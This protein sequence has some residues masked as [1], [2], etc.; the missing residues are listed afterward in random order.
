MKISPLFI[1]GNWTEG[2]VLDRHVVKSVP[3]G[4]DQWG[5]MR[6][7]TTRSE[8]GELLYGLKNQGKHQN[9]APIVEIATDFLLKDM[10]AQDAEFIIPVP[11]TDTTRPYQPVF[12]IARGIA[13]RMGLEYKEVL[14]KRDSIQAKN[15]TSDT[16]DHEFDL[17]GTLPENSNILL[18]DD[19]I[20]TGGTL[21]GCIDA[22]QRNLNINRCYV[23]ALTYTKGARI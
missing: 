21:S 23:L 9:I 7:D 3:I 2:Y 16:V 4:E 8:L 20:N 10:L 19:I 6:F 11:P 1:T 17:I 13:D 5:H 22:L 18:F 15:A 12:E 14:V